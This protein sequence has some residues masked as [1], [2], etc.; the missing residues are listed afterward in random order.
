MTVKKNFKVIIVGA[1]FSGLCMGIQLKKN[2]EHDFIII[3][4]SDHVG[5]TWHENKYPGAEC[6]VE[7]HLYSFS[8]EPNPDWSRVY[9]GSDEICSYL[10]K[11]AKKYD[12]MKHI[13]FGEFVKETV[14][15]QDNEWRVKTAKDAYTS[16]FL[17]FSSSPLHYAVV[18]D[19]PGIK[20]FQGKV[21]HTSKWERNFDFTGKKVG[22]IG[23]AASG[24]QCFPYLQ[25]KSK[26]VV[27]YQR[28]P[29]WILPKGNRNFHWIEKFLFKWVPFFMFF[30]RCL[31]CFYHECCWNTFFQKSKTSELMEWFG[32][33]YI[34]RTLRNHPELKK[35]LTPTYPPGCKRLLLSD[36]FYRHVRKPNVTVLTE[37]DRI[38]ANSMVDKEGK[39]HVMDVLVLATGFD[40]AGG[41]NAVKIQ[42]KTIIEPV[43]ETSEENEHDEFYGIYMKNKKNFF[44]LLGFNSGS[45]YTSVVL[46]IE[47]QVNHIMEVLKYMN[48]HDKQTIQIKAASLKEFNEDIQ[49]KT[50]PLVITQ[51]NNWYV[52]NKKNISLYPESVSIFEKNLQKLEFQEHFTFE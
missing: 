29:Q 4:K 48:K 27:V 30:Y 21:L 11:C 3:E 35:K 12:L 44:T 24:I 25:Q 26:E 33:K 32:L 41:V 52:R 19:I 39:E 36:D 50:K 34:S 7:S 22:M 5:G 49:E 16:Q 2:N 9:S 31:I 46:Y 42:D 6:D 18:P 47:S 10:E 13:H 38:T 17:V 23:C 20:E 37:I 1:G 43:K 40:L 15:E 45:T 51:C 8:F 14:F 28:T